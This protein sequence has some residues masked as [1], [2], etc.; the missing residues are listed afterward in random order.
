MRKKDMKK[1]AEASQAFVNEIQM[2]R[3]LI[4]EG[5]DQRHITCNVCNTKQ[6]VLVDPA[7][8]ATYMQG[9]LVQD[10]WPEADAV[11]REQMIGL[12]SGYHVCDDCWGSM[13]DDY[14][15]ED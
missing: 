5:W 2:D 13:G 4:T 3:N 12:R 10:V 7:R 1:F 8:W 6:D 15:D 14:D 11:Y 9:A